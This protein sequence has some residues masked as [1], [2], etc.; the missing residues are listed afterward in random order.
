MLN[1][2]LWKA[3]NVYEILPQLLVGDYMVM[4]EDVLVGVV[5]TITGV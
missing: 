5:I 1:T 2:V 3:V 4:I